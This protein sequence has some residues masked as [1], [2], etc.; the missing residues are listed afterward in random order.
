MVSCEALAGVPMVAASYV[1]GV[2][3]PI[4]KGG[5]DFGFFIQHPMAMSA[6]TMFLSLDI[7]ARSRYVKQDWLRR[8]RGVAKCAGLGCMGYGG[9]IIY[10]NKENKD[11]P[12]LGSL[13]GRLGALAIVLYAAQAVLR[14]AG[15][16]KAEDDEEQAERQPLLAVLGVAGLAVGTGWFQTELTGKGT[17]QKS[18]G[19]VAALGVFVASLF[20]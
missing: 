11:K 4:V 20:S 2:G 19:W 10:R 14:Q 12:H 9:Y 16:L 18:L 13:H 8:L 7:I 5:G 3:A 1:Q 6:G 15:I 17:V